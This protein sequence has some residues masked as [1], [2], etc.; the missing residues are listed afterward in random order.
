VL[1]DGPG[2]RGGLAPGDEIVA[3]D[4][5][6]VDE[7]SLRERLAGRVPGEPVRVA[8]FRREELLEIEV[9]LGARPYDRFEVAPRADADE[10]ARARYQ[11]WLGEPLPAP[12]QG[13]GWAADGRRPGQPGS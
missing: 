11:A 2:E 12:A 10:A 4:A 6:R 13:A 3:L 8:L 9:T 7:R 5:F 1:A